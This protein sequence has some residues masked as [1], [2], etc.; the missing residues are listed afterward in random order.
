MIR[1]KFDVIYF[2]SDLKIEGIKQEHTIIK[3]G[4]YLFPSARQ[5]IIVHALKDPFTRLLESSM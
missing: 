5:Q 4:T 1:K 2:E 3:D